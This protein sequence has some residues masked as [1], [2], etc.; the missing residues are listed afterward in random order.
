MKDNIQLI[1]LKSE[2]CGHC[3][4]FLPIFKKA[5]SQ[6]ICDYD[7]YDINDDK[8]YTSFE[9]NYPDIKQ[10][11]DKAVPT[12]YII[13]NDKFQE[14]R[15]SRVMGE[16]EKELNI[17]VNTFIDNVKNGIKTLQSDNHTVYIQA[18]GNKE[19][20][21]NEEYYK[22]KYIKYKTKY[23]QKKIK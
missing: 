10:K 20:Y 23:L 16:G 3:K 8:K 22:N 4:S 9:N 6:N 18:G 21:K 2:E 15:S 12:I 7:I 17:A 19:Y 14:V 5:V 1:L 11:F 13:V